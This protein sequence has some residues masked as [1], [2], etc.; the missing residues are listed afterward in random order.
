MARGWILL[1]FGA[2]LPNWRGAASR[3]ARQADESGWFT[4]VLKYDEA[5]L[6]REFPN[7]Y[8]AHAAVL[9]PRIRGFGYWIWKPFLIARALE[10]AMDSGAAGVVYLDSGFEL[11]SRSTAATKR[12]NEYLDIAREQDV[13]AMHLPGHPEYAWTRREVMD[14]V[15]LPSSLRQTPQVQATPVMKASARSLE[16]AE[17]W[18]EYCV[19]DDYRLVRDHGGQEIDQ[20]FQAHRHDQSVFSCLTKVHGFE[21][22]P[23]ET[24]W[25]PDWQVRGAEYPL[26]AMRNRTRVRHS[27]ASGR[28]RATRFIEKAY[29]RV[30]RQAMD[31]LFR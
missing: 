16:F 21:T 22:I 31:Q 18:S 27:D 12:L 23:D 8:N 28:A 14:A 3:L 30:H 13:F 24:F 10:R 29:S 11:N 6:R 20:R 1:T 19:R 2:G 26:W 5:R 17:T 25:A 4:E 15:D 9:S 7:F